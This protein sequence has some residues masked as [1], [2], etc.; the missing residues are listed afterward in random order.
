MWLSQMVQYPEH[1]SVEMVFIGRVGTGKGMFIKLLSNILGSSR[2]F[3]TA[4]PQRD[5]YGNFNGNLVDGFLIVQNE[6]N[7]SNTYGKADIK[8]DLITDDTISIN[9]KG[10]AH[11]SMKSF[12]RFITFSNNDDPINVSKE[13]GEVLFLE[14]IKNLK[15]LNIMKR[16]FIMPMTVML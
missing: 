3:Q 4:N 6:A 14:T 1:K 13:I 11:F 8:K 10:G 16:G 2:V 15:K 7:K 5:L 9:I 12:H